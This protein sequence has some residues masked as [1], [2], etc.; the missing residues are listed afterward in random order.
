MLEKCTFSGC[1]SAPRNLEVTEV[2]D[3]SVSV[4]WKTPESDNGKPISRYV[5]ERR[6]GFKST[7]IPVGTTD[8]LDYRVIRLVA[9]NE[10]VIQVRAQ[11]E[12]GLGEPAELSQGITAKSPFCEWPHLF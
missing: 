5:I 9:G 2:T 8:S 6:D 7:Y 3:T 1:P 10:Y 11:N 12:I 4:R